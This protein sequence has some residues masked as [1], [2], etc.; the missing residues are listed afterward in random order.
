MY[1]TY[2]GG[3][4]AG[5]MFRKAMYDTTNGV[6]YLSELIKGEHGGKTG[7]QKKVVCDAVDSETGEV[8]VLTETS[9]PFAEWG[10]AIMASASVPGIFPNTDLLGHPLMDGMAAYNTDIEAAIKRC[11]EI[12]PDKTDGTKNIILDILICND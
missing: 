12:V 5:M 7:F 3:S 6:N 10:K 1:T 8:N 9:V 2:P 4:I 11:L